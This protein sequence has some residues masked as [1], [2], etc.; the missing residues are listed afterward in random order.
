MHAE[1][2]FAALGRF[3]QQYSARL[4][5]DAQ[6][7]MWG[8][9]GQQLT[10]IG[11]PFARTFAQFAVEEKQ[12][13]LFGA[14]VM[15]GSEPMPDLLVVRDAPPKRTR[16]ARMTNVMRRVKLHNTD[17]VK[18]TKAKEPKAGKPAKVKAV[19]AVKPTKTKTAKTTKVKPAKAVKPTKAKSAKTKTVKAV[20][21]TKTK[22]VKTVKTARKAR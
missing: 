4:A 5:D 3:M 14:R 22:A 7:N 6:A 21:T 8:R 11:T 17:E 12:A 16:R 9:V 15:N 18:A 19:K 2:K 1:N 10:E 13:A 20:K